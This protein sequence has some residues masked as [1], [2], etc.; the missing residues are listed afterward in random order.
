MMKTLLANP[1]VKMAR[2]TAGLKR[3]EAARR[4]NVNVR[5]LRRV[6]NGDGYARLTPGIKARIAAALEI[7]PTELLFPEV[8]D[9]S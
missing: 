5:F 7:S 3:A 9:E 8:S 2:Q 1:L 6:E 4:A